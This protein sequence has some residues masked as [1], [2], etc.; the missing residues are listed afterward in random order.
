MD[1]TKNGVPQYGYSNQKYTKTGQLIFKEIPVVLDKNSP[2]IQFE[3][4]Y[5][6]SKIVKLFGGNVIKG[7][8]TEQEA[9]LVT[10][11]LFNEKCKKLFAKNYTE[12]ISFNELKYFTQ[13]TTIPQQMFFKKAIKSIEFPKNLKHIGHAVFYGAVFDNQNF[14]IPDSVTSYGVSTFDFSNLKSITG[15]NIIYIYG[16]IVNE[17]LELQEINFPKLKEVRI[18]EDFPDYNP[19]LIYHNPKLKSINLPELQTFYTTYPLCN[20]CDSLEEVICPKLRVLSL[21]MLKNSKINKFI[22]GDKINKILDYCKIDNNAPSPSIIKFGFD[23]QV[24]IYQNSYFFYNSVTRYNNNSTTLLI[25]IED[26]SNVQFSGK[27]I[28]FIGMNNIPNNYSKVKISTETFNSLIVENNNYIA[29][30]NLGFSEIH[31]VKSESKKIKNFIL[32]NSACLQK[33]FLETD[34]KEI[35][36]LAFKYCPTLEE[37]HLNPELEKIGNFAFA[38]WSGMYPATYALPGGKV[39][40]LQSFNIPKNVNYIGDNPLLGQEQLTKTTLTLDPEN[41]NFILENGILYNKDKS[42]IILVTCDVELSRIPD[43]VK[44]IGAGAFAFNKYTGEL[45]IPSS[46]KKIGYLAFADSKFSSIKFEDSIDN[47]VFEKTGN[48]IIYIFNTLQNITLSNFYGM[49]NPSFF[50][51]GRNASKQE[52]NIL[53]LDANID[54]DNYIRVSLPNTLYSEDF[55]LL[56]PVGVKAYT[57]KK[58]NDTYVKSKTYEEGKIIPKGEAVTLEGEQ[59]EYLFPIIKNQITEKDKDNILIG[60]D[61]DIEGN[62]KYYIFNNGSIE[63]SNG[64][65]LIKENTVYIKQD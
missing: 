2:I 52:L 12:K 28:N 21:C 1:I 8:I 54:Q 65:N 41:K 56:V 31:I 60:T 51:K 53:K 37:V 59:G 22:L 45:T 24:Q 49:N 13:V 3:N 39:H 32:N 62:G 55:D 5:V 27:M 44:E 58:V 48:N 33:L 14:V 29:N 30:I 6:K 10:N 26:L 40:Y 9:A 47:I 16:D 4:D 50:V 61:K 35:E 7:E 46:V 38:F 19:T 20:K 15:N 25:P 11:V 63:L 64:L 43:T 42:K 23:N 36:D 17:C 57:Y 18:H 34:I